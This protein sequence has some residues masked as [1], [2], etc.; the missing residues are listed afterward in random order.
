VLSKL[1][2]IKVLRTAYNKAAERLRGPSLD[3]NE[4]LKGFVDGNGWL[5]TQPKTGTNLIAGTLAFYNAETLGVGAYSF[6]DIYRLGLVHGGRIIRDAGGLTEAL[7]F[8]RISTRMPIVRWHDDIPNAHP[9][10]VICTTRPVLD[11][12]ASLWHYKFRPQNM[13]VERSIPEMVN[14]FAARN[15]AQVGAISRA[16]RAIV[17]DYNDLVTDPKT[18]LSRVITNAYGSLD[19]AALDVALK[20]SSKSEFKKWEALRGK[21]AISTSLAAH[22]SSFIRSGKTGEGEDFFSDAQKQTI[23]DLSAAAG[24]DMSGKIY[25]VKDQ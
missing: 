7:R 22:E 14:Y 20:R 21:P 9:E 24:L 15:R 16:D 4:I 12:L 1:K 10:L 2:K 18:A 6:D 13:T 25:S 3:N 19:D 11:Q 5:F 17:I 8:Q 23:A